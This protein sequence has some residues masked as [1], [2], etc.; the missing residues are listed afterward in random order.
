VNE[1]A[2]Q[3]IGLGVLV[4]AEQYMINPMA[5]YAILA[6]VWD[7]LANIFAQ[8]SWLFGF[9]AMHARANYYTVV[10]ANGG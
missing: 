1:T 5:G 3:L 8:L 2:V 7:F 6:K 4:L 9:A 10:N